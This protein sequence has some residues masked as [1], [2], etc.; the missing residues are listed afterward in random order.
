[1]IFYFSWNWKVLS[2]EPIFQSTEDIDKKAVELLKA[3]SQNECRRCF[4]AWKACMGRCVA[5]VVNYFE[6]DDIAIL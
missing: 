1:V 3:L 4:E 6:G 5:T 2:K